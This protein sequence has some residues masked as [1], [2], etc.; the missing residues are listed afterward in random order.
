MS[1]RPQ[2]GSFLLLFAF[3]A[4][5]KD[6]GRIKRGDFPPE[7]GRI[8]SDNCSVSGC[9]NSFSS[10]AAG[11]LDLSSWQSLFAGTPHG[12]PVIPYASRFSS[13]FYFINTYGDLG[14][15]GSP[16]MPLNRSPLSR[17]EVMRIKSWI[18]EGAP[19]EKGNV[20]FTGDA[21]R[22]K[23]YVVNQ[24]CDVVTVMDAKTQL[25]MRYVQVGNKSGPDTPHQVRVSA[26]GK[27]W[28]V[29]F[30]NNNIMQKYRCSDDSYVGDIPLTP[31][32]AG[33]TSDPAYDAV[34]WNTFV[35]SSD[36]K[37]AYCVSWTQ[38]GRVA[39]VD[40]ENR[41]LLHF[42]GGLYYPHAVVLNGEENRIFVGAQTGNFI[43]ELDTALNSI[44]EW[45]L[46]DKINLAS[47]LDIHDLILSP[48][49]S[50]LVISCQQ[51]ND[52]RFF[53]LASKKV[54]KVIPTGKLPQEIVYSSLRNEYYVSCPSDTTLFAR[55][56]GVVTK[57]PANGTGALNVACGTQPHGLAVD[58]ARGLLY[59]LS[60]NISGNGPAPHHVSACSG[61]NGYLSFIDLRTFTVG[62]RRYEL[63][64]DP[65]FIFAQP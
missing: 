6:V 15:G 22:K 21:A 7:V 42:T 63:S 35:I 11:D 31:F 25:P 29:I 39:A 28:Y 65:Y 8:F 43:T 46:E 13:L 62:D 14:P 61:R 49:R 12:L 36:S 16:T 4:C 37:K 55:S 18:D 60:R 53:D 24:G 64:V 58:D 56:S 48:D 20:M 2:I 27:Y 10:K 52:V 40:L 32:A 59:V 30:V 3:T 54:T 5:T 45:S 41:K 50:Q 57:I 44:N 1:L 19:D 38:N 26:D 47:S 51:S 9:H 17:D 23:L 33:S 34:N